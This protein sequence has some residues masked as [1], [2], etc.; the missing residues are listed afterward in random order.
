MQNWLIAKLKN[1]KQTQIKMQTLLLAQLVGFR[2]PPWG[3]R[4][5]RGIWVNLIPNPVL[6][7]SF[8][9]FLKIQT[10]QKVK[11]LVLSILV[12]TICSIFGSY[13]VAPH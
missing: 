3:Q 5:Q 10:F 12:C 4:L 1:K 11:H 9:F 2:T 7:Q 6:T 8:I 13:L